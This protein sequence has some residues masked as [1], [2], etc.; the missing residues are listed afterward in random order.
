M[1]KAIIMGVGLGEGVE[2]AIYSSL[3]MYNPNK[4]IFLVTEE[5]KK[6]LSRKIEPENK[7]LIEIVQPNEVHVI[8]NPEELDSTF[9]QCKNAVMNLINEGY[10]F[11]EI[12]VD[13][14]SGTKVMSAVLSSVAILYRLDGIVYVRGQRNEKGIVIKGTEKPNAIK[15]RNILIEYDIELLKSYF[16]I[17]QFES[18]QKIL[19]TIIDDASIANDQEKI[20]IF[21]DLDNILNAFKKWERF[22]N[23]KALEFFEKV[24]TIDVKIQM[25]YLRSFKNDLK[26]I[27]EKIAQLKPGVSINKNPTVPTI[28]D[29]LD[30]FHNSSRRAVEG[31]FDDAV[32]RLYRCFEMIGQHL[33]FVECRQISSA[34]D[35]EMIRNEIPSD[36]F[37]RLSNTKNGEK[38]KI[39]AID[40]F[41]ILSTIKKDHPVIKQYIENKNNIK[42]YLS[43]RNDSILAHG[44]KPINE[45]NY[46]DMS[47]FIKNFLKNLISDVDDKLKNIDNC[48]N[49]KIPNF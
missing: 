28:S 7:A 39:G 35:L 17:Y 29:I 26:Q 8:I 40:G 18:C 12:N 14:T 2:Y 33:L 37:D 6:T 15:P 5:S 20:K 24:E 30:I 13:I 31:K 25:N 38:I 27:N 16:E 44:T 36:F 10:K 21:S 41:E 32:A 48:F 23:M 11:T 9:S 42:K 22:D 46:F 34:F 19:K 45:D 3:K 43:F 4:V 1:K 47:E 49:F